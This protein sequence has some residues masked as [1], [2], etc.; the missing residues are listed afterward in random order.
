MSL[1]KSFGKESVKENTRET[2]T[3]S[4]EREE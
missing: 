2:F 1:K 4:F 3:P